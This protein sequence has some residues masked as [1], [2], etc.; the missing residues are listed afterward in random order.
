LLEHGDL[1]AVRWL[2]KTYPKRKIARVVKSSRQISRKTANFWRLRLG[3]AASEVF[4]L[5]RRPVL[6]SDPFE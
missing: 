6:S 2:V 4:V 1:S 5:N 3:L